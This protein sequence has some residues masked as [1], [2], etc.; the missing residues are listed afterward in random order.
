MMETKLLLLLRKY[1]WLLLTAAIV[2]VLF[3]SFAGAIAVFGWGWLGF[4]ATTG[5]VLR[6]NEQYRPAKTLWDV[7]QLVIVPLVLAGVG[8]W[9]TQVQKRNEQTIANDNQRETALQAYIG[10]MSELLLTHD[11][12]ESSE[13][14]E[15][16]DI[17]R[18]R[19]LTVLQ[20]LD[21]GRK[22]SVLLFL[23]EAGLIYKDKTSTKTGLI[24]KK[25]IIGLRRAD[26]SGVKLCG[27]H[28][29]RTHLSGV[30]LSGADLGGADL[31]EAD[32]TGTNF[33]GAKL[34]G[35]D[36]RD[37]ILSGANLSRADLGGADLSGADLGEHRFNKAELSEAFLSG[38]DL[39]PDGDGYV[40]LREAIVTW[41]QLKKAK[42][43]EGAIIPGGSKNP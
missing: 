9:F 28:L 27:A 8:L 21:A 36:F 38:A 31:R 24:Y 7:L 43:L 39:I 12:R 37:A 29:S 14:E 19:T 5:P 13:K 32:L 3:L 33:T 20:R 41:E 10:G 1:K 40:K 2:I 4:T 35:V 34:N 6:P 42:S 25:T 15:V 16:R 23:L 26:F 18:V 11:L 17:A 30:N 22:A